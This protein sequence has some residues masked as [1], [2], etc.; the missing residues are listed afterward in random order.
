MSIRKGVLWNGFNTFEVYSDQIEIKITDNSLQTGHT[1]MLMV[2]FK[3]LMKVWLKGTRCLTLP[4]NIKR[5]PGWRLFLWGVLPVFYLIIVWP[6]LLPQ[7]LLTLHGPVMNWWSR[8][9][10]YLTSSQWQ[11]G[12]THQCC[13]SSLTIFI[14][15]VKFPQQSYWQTDG[16]V[17]LKTCL[18]LGEG[19]QKTASVTLKRCKYCHKGIGV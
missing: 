1:E 17:A 9:G 15:E 19:M 7:S 6:P 5:V 4:P 13:I 18:S 12:Y 2:C 14:L 10:V 11:L 3:V 8:Q 16:Q